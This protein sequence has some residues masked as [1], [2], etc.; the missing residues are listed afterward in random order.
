MHH[1][2]IVESL[3]IIS[4]FT[5]FHD[6]FWAGPVKKITLYLDG[7]LALL[8]VGIVEKK[9]SAEVIW[10]IV[11][12]LKVFASQDGKYIFGESKVFSEGIQHPRRK[13]KKT[14]KVHEDVIDVWI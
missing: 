4:V 7:R 8:G 5:F 9:I 6:I 10:D 14:V 12:W 11:R 1:P 2:F 3:A 13:S